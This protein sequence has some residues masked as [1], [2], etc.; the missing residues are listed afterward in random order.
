MIGF[1]R[2][3]PLLQF[4]NIWFR[5]NIFWQNTGEVGIDS[6]LDTSGIHFQNNLWSKVYPRDSRARTGEPSFADP[7]ASTPEGYFLK[8]GS[9][10]IDAGIL[11]YENPLDFRNGQRP[12][13][14]NT[15]AYDIGAHEYGST[16]KAHIGLDLTTFP[17]EVTPYKLQFKAKPKR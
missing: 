1:L 3:P 6:G 16:G 17:F 4:R 9:A 8:S 7:N 14:P 13:L 10:A 15:G 2:R 5:N 11:L 12:H